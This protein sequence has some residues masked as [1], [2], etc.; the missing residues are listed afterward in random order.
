M[1][2]FFD[3]ENIRNIGIVGHTGCGKT[4][5]FEHILFE[6]GEIKQPGSIDKG[7]TVSDVD[8]EE[9]NRKISLKSTFASIEHNNHKINIIDNPGSS[10]FTGEVRA[11][12]RIADGLIFVVDSE[13]GV[14]IE[15][16]KQWHLADDYNLPRLVFINKMD[17]NPTSFKTIAEDI[18]TNFEKSA[19][20]VDL[21]II[22]N[23][24]MTGVVDLLDLTAWTKDG[25]HMKEIEIPDSMKDEVEEAYGT[26]MEAV[27]EAS[28]QYIEK[29]LGGEKLTHD[30]M[31]DG[32]LKTV[33]ENKFI[34]IICGSNELHIGIKSLLRISYEAFPSSAYKK[35]AKGK[36]SHGN[37]IELKR[38]SDEKFSA[39]CF[40][41]IIDQFSGKLSY[42]QIISGTLKKDDEI[43]IANNDHSIKVSKILVPMG[44]KYTE[45]S[46][47]STGDIVI[48]Q[49]IDNLSTSDTLCI[50]EKKILYP[51]LRFTQSAH[52]VAIHVNDK[53]NED[54]LLS[55]LHKFSEEDPTLKIEFNAETHENVLSARG[56][57]HLDVY[58]SKIKKILNIEIE[59][60]IPKINY[61][62]T[63]KMEADEK[64]R[65]K[66]QSGGHGQF[67]EVAIKVRPSKDSTN[68]KFINS[69]VG[70]KVP[71]QYIPGVEKGLVE[72]MEQG[73][74]AK[75]PVVG[76]E[77]ELYDGQFHPVDSSEM[78]FKIAAKQA[79]KGALQK[80]QSVLLEPIM[81][82][83]VY[84]PEKYVGDI[85][86]DL[87]SK[88]GK[89]V[90][91]DMLPGKNVLIKADVPHSELLRYSVD[92]KALTQSTGSFEIKFDHYS[93]ITGKNADTIIESRKKELE[94]EE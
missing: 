52:A 28:D 94:A 68:F 71:K 70:G 15:T 4:M 54:K 67:G 75:F 48:L 19:V 60:T 89:I 1:N 25:E 81:H 69:I 53:K 33:E 78:A 21:P 82:L 42:I 6:A 39:F 16:I 51:K 5:L 3:Q 8:E 55:M 58:F 9:K 32:F 92:L 24:I 66:K 49:K 45:V 17:K 10:D 47:G 56:E 84:A 93:P 77:V 90:G 13:S 76:I 30:E 20:P 85:M 63:I 50:K 41:T 64:Y 87:S 23:G 11:S 35:I 88:R 86:S 57:L 43:F 38:T 91:Q 44:S 34:P 79:L 26:L 18:K 46:Q 2:K 12:F 80:A 37:E 59:T 65:H 7:T 62:E 14:Q 72:G 40:K 22:E 31:L 27:A 29:F 83:E 73:I 74:L 61:K 36:D